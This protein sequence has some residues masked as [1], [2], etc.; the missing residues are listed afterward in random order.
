MN[1]IDIKELR[2]TLIK[3]N[4]KIEDLEAELVIKNYEVQALRKDRKKTLKEVTELYNS[5]L[6]EIEVNNVII[7]S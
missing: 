2:L 4:N 6:E 7:V 3:A 1:D 5:L